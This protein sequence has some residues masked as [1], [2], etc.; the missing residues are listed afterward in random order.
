[1]TGGTIL[2]RIRDL[3]TFAG[4]PEEDLERLVE[5]VTV[6]ELTS[7]EVF[8][9]QGEVA[10][11]AYLILEGDVEI[12]QS[13]GDG[14]IV[15]ATRHA[16]ELVGEM[17]LLMDAPRNA[18]VRAH[19]TATVIRI[20]AD[21]FQAMLLSR[22]EIAIGMLRTIW[23]RLQ[24][25][26]VR[27]VHH[28]KMAA[29]GTLAAG[30]AHELNNPAA[31]LSRSTSQLATIVLNWEQ[32]SNSLGSLS[33]STVERETIAEL[34][35][36]I[37]EAPPIDDLDP[38]DRAELEDEIQAWLEAR[39][40]NES[41]R[42]APHLSKTRSPLDTLEWIGGRVRDEH[43]PAILWW[44]G[45]GALIH[46]LLT[47]QSL[48]GKAISDIVTAIKAY[49]QL[50]QAPVQEINIHDGI[51]QALVILRHKL[52]GI[53]VERKYAGNLPR[54]TVYA[55]ELNQVWTNLID[56]AADA[57]AGSG[58][59]T[60]ATW[61]EGRSIVVQIADN[62]PGI[63]QDIQ[64]SVFDPFFTTKPP[65]QG[66]GIGLAISFNIVR[67][68]SGDIRLTSEQGRTSFEVRLPL[69]NDVA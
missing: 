8:I 50:D 12:V 35:H 64:D 48:S 38:L 57:L 45:T 52:R 25:A 53:R 2:D 42:L 5:G 43:L 61:Q 7:N 44:F 33:L 31:A 51:D 54:I 29:L 10:D 1:M 32:E 18:K 36:A 20:A 60:I 19:P 67:K 17:A 40:V 26:E 65:G 46:Q 41:W 13:S 11:A 14:E 49:T 21:R 3:P 56:N 37:D 66:T 28:Q 6:R 4:V 63:P 68:H 9:I 58:T 34:R 30:L 22:P 16:G 62:G 15:V 27:L 23:E 59:I 69:K 47:D 39:D 24:E 55:G